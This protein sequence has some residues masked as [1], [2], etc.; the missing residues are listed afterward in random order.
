V[1]VLAALFTLD[2]AGAVSGPLEY[3]DTADVLA[4]LFTLDSVDGALTPPQPLNE[5]IAVV[6]H[7]AVITVIN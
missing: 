1:D 4:A 5:S 2:G 3:S 6:R 7:A